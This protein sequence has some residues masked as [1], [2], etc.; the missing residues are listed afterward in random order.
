MNKLTRKERVLKAMENG[1]SISPWYAINELGNTRLAATIHQLKKDG[2]KITSETKTG[3]N[4][5]GENISYSIYRLM[6]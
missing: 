6:E 3:V 5:F 4:K 1:R 2:Y